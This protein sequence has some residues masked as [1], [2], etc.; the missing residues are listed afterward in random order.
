[1]MPAR[2]SFQP[3]FDALFATVKIL[4][5]LARTGQTLGG[6]RRSLPR[7]AYR[8]VQVPCSWDLKGGLMRRMSEHS[9]DLQASFIDGVKVELEGDSVLVLPD[10][11]RPVVHV[12]AESVAPGRADAL[13]T[14]YRQ[15]VERW[16]QELQE[17]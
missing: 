12:V 13:V 6:I 7:Q 3:H 4:E 2:W 8:H 11:Y 17:G 9:V 15:L 14:T 5:L 16:K 1:M 10:Q